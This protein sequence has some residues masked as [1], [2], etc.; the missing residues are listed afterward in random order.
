MLRDDIDHWFFEPI[1]KDHIPA[2][3]CL[4]SQTFPY[5]TLRDADLVTVHR[6]QSGLLY[7][8]NTLPLPDYCGGGITASGFFF[9]S[10]FG[11]YLRRTSATSICDN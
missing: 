7:L 3:K 5:K 8:E 1:F 4:A 11:P 2:P 9:T 10:C 6:R